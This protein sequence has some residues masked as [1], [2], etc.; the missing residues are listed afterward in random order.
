VTVGEC[1]CHWLLAKVPATCSVSV[2]SGIFAGC[3]MVWVVGG[4][5]VLGEFC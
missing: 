4:V 2:S 1:Q 3:H 5:H